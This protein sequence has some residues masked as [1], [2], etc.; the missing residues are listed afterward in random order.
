M[1][2]NPKVKVRDAYTRFVEGAG[3]RKAARRGQG[4]VVRLIDAAPASDGYALARYFA[5]MTPEHLA[6]CWVA[7]IVELSVAP[8]VRPSE[9]A[10]PLCVVAERLCRVRP[11]GPRS[12]A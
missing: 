10:R 11:A 5:S 2:R 6:S 3:S 1:T 7:C 4:M 12:K 8:G 9:I